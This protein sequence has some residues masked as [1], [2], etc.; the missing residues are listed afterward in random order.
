VKA[1]G[2]KEKS[3]EIIA[4]GA[5]HQTVLQ[6]RVDETQLRWKRFMRAKKLA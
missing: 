2:A 4:S 6:R 3:E 1:T 5:S